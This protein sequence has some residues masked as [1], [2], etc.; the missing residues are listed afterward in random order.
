MARG[1]KHV[2]GR[3]GN[4]G[5]GDA[6]NLSARVEAR[7]CRSTLPRSRTSRFSRRVR[8][9]HRLQALL[10]VEQGGMNLR[11]GLI[12]EACPSRSRAAA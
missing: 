11:R 7:L 8:Y 4:S 9:A 3:L 12:D 5:S 1:W 6:Y 2:M 10:F